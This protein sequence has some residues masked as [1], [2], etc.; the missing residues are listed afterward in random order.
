MARDLIH[1]MQ[2]LFLKDFR[3]SPWQPLVDV[4]RTADGWLVKFDL[5]G[6]RPEDITLSLR[7]NRLTVR[8]SRRDCCLEGTC[9][10]YL[11]EISYSHFERTLTLPEEVEALRLNTEYRD[12]MLLVRLRKDHA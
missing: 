11:M 8:G 3:E 7:G 2:H 9:G 4:Y 1:Q 6:V 12:G 5:A 10:Q